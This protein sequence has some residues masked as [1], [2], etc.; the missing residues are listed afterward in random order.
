MM[1]RKLYWVT[2]QLDSDGRAAITG[3]FTSAPD[4]IGK[5]LV[6]CDCTDKRA[7]FRLTLIALDR[8]GKP[9]GTWTGPDF[10]GMDDDLKAFVDTGEF[11]VEEHNELCQAVDHFAKA[12]V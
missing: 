11:S 8:A 1:F 9:L 10:A 4:L 6:W 3:V 12:A 5:G 7:S 2:E